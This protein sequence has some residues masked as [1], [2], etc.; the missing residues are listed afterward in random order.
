MSAT[1]TVG[2]IIHLKNSASGGGYLD[3]Y[4]WVDLIL[5]LYSSA[6]KGNH[7]LADGLRVN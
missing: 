4:G 3:T 5:F 7:N 6:A 1:I 2:S